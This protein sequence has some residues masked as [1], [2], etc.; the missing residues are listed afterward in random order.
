MSIP[1]LPPEILDWI[2]DL[3]HDEPEALKRC[4]L[5]SK[6]WV[7][8]TRIHLFEE[9]IFHDEKRMKLWKKTFPDPSTSPARYV[10]YLFFDRPQ[11]VVA[12]DAEPGAWI[13]GF[14]H[15]VHLGVHSQESFANGSFSLVPFHGISPVL[16]SL[17][18]SVPALPSSWII[19]LSLSFPLLEDLA[20]DAVTYYG[21]LDDNDGSFNGLLTAIQPPNPPMFTGSLELDMKG[22]I[23][24]ITRRLLSPP[25]GIHFWRL[26]LTW[27]H[28]A[29]H[30][31]T[32]ALVE[33]C[34]H[35]LECLEISDLRGVSNQHMC[36]NDNLL[37]FLVKPISAS[38]DLSK[39]TKLKNVEFQPVSRNVKWIPATLRTALK[40]RDLREISIYLP[41]Y[42]TATS[43]G[44]DVGR[45]IG[46]EN[47]RE[48]LDLDRLLVQFW[49]SSSIR[50]KVVS[51]AQMDTEDSV[52]YQCLLPE[53]TKRGI[54]D[55][56][57]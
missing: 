7:P 56:M 40:L 22:G 2:V 4:C 43:V 9:I 36:H 37:L 41:N 35:T 48:W 6:S 17:R 8:R 49:E 18:V 11:V 20:V 57:P 15:V 31:A 14:S 34:S 24:P 5:V 32:T 33:R 30:L 45:V 39:A 28:E 29:D 42:I 13:S 12:A 21:A 19:D 44:T 25:R 55:L 52:G 50:P 47:G 23:E 53:I 54:I 51:L 46:E 26:A 3:L 27:S 1:Y 38:A 10:K 16:E